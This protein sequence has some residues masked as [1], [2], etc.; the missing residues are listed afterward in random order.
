MGRGR[1]WQASEDEALCRAWLDHASREARNQTSGVWDAIFAAFKDAFPGTGRSLRAVNNRW[2]TIQY[3]VARF[4]AKYNESEAS[5]SDDASENDVLEKAKELYVELGA[6]FTLPHCWAIL[7]QSTQL[8]PVPITLEATVAPPVSSRNDSNQAAACSNL[9]EE[10]T[11]PLVPIAPTTARVLHVCRSTAV[12]VTQQ[13][14]RPV[15]ETT[16]PQPRREE[17]CGCDSDTS[18]QDVRASKR[19]RVEEHKL[20]L[21]DRK[22]ELQRRQMEMQCELLREQLAIQREQMQFQ[23]AQFERQ[24]DIQQQQMQL[25]LELVQK[26]SKDRTT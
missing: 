24:M 10:T 11:M 5:L 23:R 1:A 20:E 15:P 22:L 12:P 17:S 7:R 9:T 25:I 14:T 26:A 13:P 19:R 18:S 6:E 3:E 8:P 2:H 16:L 4:N 21:M